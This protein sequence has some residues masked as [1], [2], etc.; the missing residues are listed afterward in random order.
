MFDDDD[1]PE[2]VRL[3]IGRRGAIDHLLAIGQYE[4]AKELAAQLIADEPHDPASWLALARVHLSASDAAPAV[5]AAAE[6]IRIAPDWGAA[7][8]THTFALLRAGRFAD[9]ET[10]VREAIRLEPD[11]SGMF[12]LYARLLSA[13]GRE[14][15]AL[16][17]AREALELDPDDE[18][19]HQLFAALLIEVK[20]SQW[21]LSEEA[22]RRAVALDPDD[23]DGFAIL[24]SIVMTQRRYPEA[25][26]HFRTA[27][28]LDPHNRLAL[29]GLAQMTM[30]KHW[31]YRPFLGY[32][33]AMS[34]LGI[35]AQLLVVAGLWAIVSV[36][37][38]VYG[39]VEPWST[40]IVI[41][42]TAIVLYTWFATPVMRAILKRKY[43]WI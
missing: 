40:V 43:P 29:R 13:C 38:G 4:R 9:A 30:A 23:S 16:A 33:L 42:Y 24:G 17:M 8:M 35:G 11:E 34:R 1:E 19:A 18:E 10:S 14:A 41:V 26:E 15:E 37:L 39:D 25:E 5:E 20:P 28:E 27:L 21:R 31:I 22:A 32:A 6:A 3:E 36:L 2:E 12:L 7:W